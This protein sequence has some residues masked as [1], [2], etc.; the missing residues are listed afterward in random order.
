MAKRLWRIAGECRW[1]A[2]LSR[3]SRDGEEVVAVRA[4]PP[5]D[6][7]ESGRSSR[8]GEEVVAVEIA[9][10]VGVDQFGTPQFPRWRRGC[11]GRRS[12][13]SQ[14]WTA[15]RSSRDGEEVVAG[16]IGPFYQVSEL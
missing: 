16:Q 8:D 1:R 11:G 13:R 9:G 7:A 2:C 12:A 3:S 4:G 14:R 15:C 6:Q 10:Q 5:V